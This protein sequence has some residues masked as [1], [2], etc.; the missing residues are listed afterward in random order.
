MI[1]IDYIREFAA[2][3]SCLSFSQASEDLFI[4]QPSLSRHVSLLEAE[5]GLKLV[6][7][8]T[9]NVYLTAAG[10][11]LYKDF[12]TLLDAYQAVEDKARSLSSGYRSRFSLSAPYY[13]IGPHIEP[14]MF[15]FNRRFP[16]VR[17][18]I[19]ICSPTRGVELLE[20]NKTDVAVSFDAF[21][22]RRGLISKCIAREP[23]GVV[24]QAGHPCAKKESVAVRDL[25]DDKFIILEL[26][27]SQTA[28]RSALQKIITEYGVAPSRF[29]FTQNLSTVGLTIRQT[30]GVSILM[31][32]FGNLGR[33]Y[34]VFVPLSD[35][36]NHNG[37][38][39]YMREDSANEAA[40]TFF[41]DLPEIK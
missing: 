25:V 23:L 30:G 21:A 41:D 34:L 33:D 35:P 1:R 12:L 32:C 8:N 7:R 26:D 6:E 29:V 22:D 15:D 3:A 38:Y 10:T 19:N 24:M 27:E 4:T 37:L 31:S 18:E 16:D 20:K 13:W 39:L 11:E 9:R 14:A 17:I 40:R 5:L 36:G 28:L 2:L